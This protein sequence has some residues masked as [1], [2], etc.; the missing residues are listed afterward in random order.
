MSLTLKRKSGLPVRLP[1]PERMILLEWHLDFVSFVETTKMIDSMTL[2]RLS[3][4]TDILGSKTLSLEHATALYELALM[5]SLP[6]SDSRFMRTDENFVICTFTDIALEAKQI[7][8]FLK[9]KFEVN[10]N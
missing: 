8:K 7:L 4:T 1:K 3:Q 2:Q 9:K 6:L 5:N 10:Y